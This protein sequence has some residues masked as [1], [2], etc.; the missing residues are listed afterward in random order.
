M[1]E[2][3]SECEKKAKGKSET[4]S[5]GMFELVNCFALVCNITKNRMQSM[6]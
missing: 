2:R 5:C 4:D 1:S 6:K 3:E